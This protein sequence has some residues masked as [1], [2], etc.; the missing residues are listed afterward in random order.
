MPT[1]DETNRDRI[2]Q[3]DPHKG[4]LLVSLPTFE[5]QVRIIVFLLSRKAVFRI[6]A[7]NGL[8]SLYVTP[9]DKATLVNT[10]HLTGDK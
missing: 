9:E 2:E 4:L 5:R 7:D 6:C 3:C 10:G 1:L 8:V